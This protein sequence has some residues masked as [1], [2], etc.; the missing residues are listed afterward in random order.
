MSRLAQYRQQ[1]FRS[2]RLSGN[3]LA[4]WSQE[5]CRSAEAVGL[6][7]LH[8]DEDT[9]TARAVAAS[10]A[11]NGCRCLSLSRSQ[12][13]LLILITKA[14]ELSKLSSRPPWHRKEAAFKHQITL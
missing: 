11:V 9:G 4:A 3:I 13:R 5:R 8:S 12:R 1:L 10:G 2:S 14:I 6:H 7:H